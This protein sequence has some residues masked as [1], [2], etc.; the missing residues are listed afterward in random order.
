MK[1]WTKKRA[2][3]LG[4]AAVMTLSLTACGEKTPSLEEVEQA[5]EAG[6]LTIE[7]ALEK[8]WIDQA[9]VDAYQEEHSV[10][11][12]SKMEANVVGDFTTTT[13]SGEEFTRDQL[14]DVVFFAF[15]DPNAEGTQTF[16]DALAEGYDGV[17]EN[18]ADIVVCTKSES[19]NELFAEAPF[20]VIL[21]N[22]SLKAAI[23]GNSGMVEDEETPNTASW[24]VNGSFLS[25]WYSSVEG[26]NLPASAAS[27]VEMSRDPA[28]KGG[29]GSGA[30]A[31]AP[32][33]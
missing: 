6:T 26:E 23:G 9:W 13:L 14:G 15:L 5:I 21:Y 33:G 18:G 29:D 32:M 24:Y 27:F 4:L 30:A 12:D 17:A 22:D 16:Y 8:G 19:G 7:D 2:A 31:M 20:P 28:F 10:P 25:A 11:A 3:A 1:F